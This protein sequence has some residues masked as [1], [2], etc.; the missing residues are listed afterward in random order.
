MS[1]AS[2][3][4]HPP[5]PHAHPPSHPPRPPPYSP[6]H[7]PHPPSHPP[8]P[9]SHPRR[10][11]LSRPL[12]STHPITIPSGLVHL[13]ECSGLQFAQDRERC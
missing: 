8:H 9:P 3:R 11:T 13:P 2:T 10:L 7:P 6:S 5:H 1:V 4:L 12:C